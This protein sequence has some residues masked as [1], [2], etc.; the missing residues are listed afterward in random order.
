VTRA[1]ITAITQGQLEKCPREHLELLNLDIPRHLVG[2]DSAYL[3]PR[4]N[5]EDSSAYDSEAR[6]LV[7]LFV[8]NI[9]KFKPSQ[10]IINAGPR[11]IT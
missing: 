1:I 11:A 10:A 6:K 5:W 7:A 9:K 2:V 8:D 3:N 4:N